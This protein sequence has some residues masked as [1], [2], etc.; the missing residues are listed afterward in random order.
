MLQSRS[1]F[2]ALLALS[3]FFNGAQAWFWRSRI[4]IGYAIVSEEQA[5]RINQDHKLGLQEFSYT[6][7]LG[8][9]F[10]LVNK[11]EN[12]MSRAGSRYCAVQAR[13][14]KVRRIAKVNIPET[15]D[16]MTPRGVRTQRL[17]ARDEKVIEEYIQTR[18]LIT[19]P[20]KALRFAWIMGL[21][22]ELQMAIPAKLLSDEKSLYLYAECFETERELAEFSK[23]VIRWDTWKITGDRGQK[24]WLN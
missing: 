20:E 17:W 7:Q 1:I 24:G 5:A 8:P 6:P 14:W 9:G 21:E 11:I 10:Y 15:Y 16:K 13:K 3:F 19:P 18:A 2:A 4:V 12:L 22:G 23:E